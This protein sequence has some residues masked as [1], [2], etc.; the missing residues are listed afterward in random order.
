MFADEDIIFG[1]LGHH[2]LPPEEFLEMI[3]GAM[4]LVVHIIGKIVRI[5]DDRTVA[6]DA[7]SDLIAFLLLT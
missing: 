7:E 2:S 5:G 6:E 3:H 1:L 4:R